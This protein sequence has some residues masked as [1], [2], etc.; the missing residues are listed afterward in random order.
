MLDVLNALLDS[1]ADDIHGYAVMAATGRAATTVYS[2][3]ER[4]RSLGWVTARWEPSA[5]E[6]RGRPRR[7]YYMLTAGGA[8][9]AQELLQST[10]PQ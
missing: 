1:D 9:K 8:V 7:R 6:A 3:L 4:L 10:A 2:V 5:P